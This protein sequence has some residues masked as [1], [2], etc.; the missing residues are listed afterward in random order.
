M[1]TKREWSSRGIRK[2]RQG[3]ICARQHKYLIMAF[4][5]RTVLYNSINAWKF[6]TS[7]R[8]YTSKKEFD[9]NL[10]KVLVCPLSKEPLR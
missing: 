10:V 9:Q 3:E 5:F 2:K 6:S 8:L 7:R 4:N 1:A